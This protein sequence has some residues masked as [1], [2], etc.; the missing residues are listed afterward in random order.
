MQDAEPFRYQTGTIRCLITLYFWIKELKCGREDTVDQ[1]RSGPPPIDNL[2]VDILCVLRRSPF[3]GVRSI[4][5]EVV[6]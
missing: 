6:I 5:E 4:A 2:D 3:R 1:P